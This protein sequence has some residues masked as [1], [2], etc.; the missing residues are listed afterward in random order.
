MIKKCKNFLT[1]FL[2]WIY[3][4][5]VGERY[6]AEVDDRWYSDGGFVQDIPSTS[7]S[8]SKEIITYL[9]GINGY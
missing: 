9:K 2:R 7:F 4:D 3:K 6:W 1:K 5:N 8:D